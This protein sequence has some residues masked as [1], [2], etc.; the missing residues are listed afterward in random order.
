MSDLNLALIGNSTI[1]A[2]IDRRASV[3]WC[4]MPDFD[5]APVFDNLLRNA[6]DGDPADAFAG[7]FAIDLA[8][9]S[10]AEQSYRKNTAVLSTTLY[11]SDGSAVEVVDFAPRFKQFGR[12]YRPV[13]LVRML[14][15][16]AGSPRLTVRLQPQSRH[17]ADTVQVTY[18][19]N[20]VRYVLEDQ[21]LRLTTDGSISAI[22]DEMAFVLDRPTT[23]ILGPDET[24]RESV[25]AMGQRFLE[26]TCAYWHEWVRYLGIPFEWQN[27]VIR[28]AITLKLNAFDDTGAIIA[29]MTSSIPEA[30]RSGRNWDYRYCWLRDAYFVVAAL[31]RL[32][33]TQTMERYLNYI[34]D[35]IADSSNGL[36]QPV[37]RING[38]GRIDEVT[39]DEL[40]GYRG[41][42]PVRMGN[43]AYTQAQNDV[44]GAAVLAAAHVFYDERLLRGDQA[45]LFEKLEILGNRAAEAFDQPDAGLW[46]YRGIAQV[47]TFSAAMC[48]AACDRLARIGARLGLDQREAHWRAT[49]DAMHATINERAWNDAAGY[50]AD[51]FDGADL[52]ASLLLLQQLGFVTAEDPRFVATVEAIGRD[53]RRGELLLRYAKE[54]DFGHPETAFTVCSF[55]YVDA[56]HAIGRA[57]EA[58]ELFEHLL[59]HVNEHGLLSEDVDLQTGELWGNFP[60]TYSMVGMINSALRLSRPWEGEF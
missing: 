46:E 26:E 8:S 28:A 21:V 54:D 12:M 18:G 11:A 37:Y 16:V 45:A 24:C 5:G 20:H 34:I 17:G 1:G 48:W 7:T 55:W 59:S 31:N 32:G 40:P 2:L 33:A 39:V 3:V 53:L 56:L 19:S 42:G 58:R 6:G 9:F 50:Y 49:A 30:P 15:P 13:M 14:R 23:L 35:R 44:Y 27:E 22:T 57:A 52:D 41:M 4:C 51:S 10:R 29:A 36:L 25:R 60:Q 38:S 43:A 47:H